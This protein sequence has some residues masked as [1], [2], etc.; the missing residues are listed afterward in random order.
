MALQPDVAVVVDSA[1]CLPPDLARGRNI[2]IVPHELVIDGRSYRDGVDI[3]PAVFYKM[4]REER[5]VPTTVAP[6][7]QEFLDRF[8]AAAEFA[9]NVL[10]ITVSAN[11]SVAHRSALAAVE[12]AGDRLA[13]CQVKV[14]DSRAAAGA[15]GLI[16]LAA[17]RWAQE[18][19]NLDQV[20]AR[21]NRLIP[22]VNMLAF[23]DNFDY[24]NR[25]GRVSKIK[26][27]T[28]SLLGVRPL[29]ELQ[30]GQARLLE[31]PRSRRRALDRLLDIMKQRTG[32]APVVVNIME[33]DAAGDALE[34]RRR[35]QVEV[36][37]R[38][39][40]IS[41]FTPVMGA[42]TGP[43]LLGV[44]FYADEGELDQTSGIETNQ[45]D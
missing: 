21:L 4:L 38:D 25:S 5:L 2:T 35:I 29:T 15:L 22:K 30:G 36:D 18:G 24:L 26:A 8:L 45:D 37:C 41:Q 14:V 33:A 23:L 17:A 13:D 1:C 27:W 7:P 28:G 34:M 12:M 43:G 16:T 40:F 31:R 20:A 6:R 19:H 42:H 32:R 9:R 39:M 44:A 10:C 3:S 11:F